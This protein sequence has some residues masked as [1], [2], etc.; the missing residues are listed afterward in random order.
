MQLNPRKPMD[1]QMQH[2]LNTGGGKEF[3]D[4]TDTLILLLDHQT[5]LYDIE[6]YEIQ[7]E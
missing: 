1:E 3:I 2:V 4:P 6:R 7:S 5:G